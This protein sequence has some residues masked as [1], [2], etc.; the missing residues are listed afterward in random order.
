MTLKHR[1]TI[2]A[3]VLLTVA[4][5]WLTFPYQMILTAGE[6]G[7][8]SP[9]P[10]SASSPATSTSGT[11]AKEQPAQAMTLGYLWTVGG[12]CMWPLGA[13]NIAVVAL[14]I[15]GYLMVRESKM[16]MP[17]L[18][19]TIQE[20]LDKLHVDEAMNICASNPSVLTNVLHSGLE[21]I[22]EGILDVSSL[23]KAME[24]AAVEESAPGLKWIGYVSVCAQVAPMI[25]LLGTV[26]GMIK[27]FQKIGKG[28]MGKPEL[29]ANDIGE[30]LITTA[31]GLI[32]GIP[33]M[34]IY[35]NLKAKYTANL[36]RMNRVLGNMVHRLVS[37]TRK[38]AGMTEGTAA[39]SQS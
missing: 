31:Y 37:A 21:R 36:T 19:P 1:W 5:M 3:L 29:L 18:V 2:L 38:A 7:T 13:V 39:G 24:E 9:P 35:F 14:A 32:I 20:A 16:L 4:V 26:S 22:S 30:A 12:W 27:A 25:G 34:L 33:A 6:S 10:A 28:G 15:Y 11:A 23:E 8:T 17:H